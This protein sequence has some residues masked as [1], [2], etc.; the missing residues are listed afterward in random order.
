MRHD[1]E[2]LDLL[3]AGIGECEHRPVGVSLARTHVH[4]ANDAVGSRCGRDEQPVGVGA[5]V[6]GG[7]GE[8][9]GLRVGAHIDRLHRARRREADRGHGQH[10]REAGAH[11]MQPT[12]SQHPCRPFAGLTQFRERPRG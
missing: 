12:F 6:L 5:M 1:D 7:I 9:D 10:R 4:A 8:V 11:E 3:V 2:P